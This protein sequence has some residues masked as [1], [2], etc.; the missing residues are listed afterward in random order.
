[1]TS[2][3][4]PDRARAIVDDLEARTVDLLAA[5]HATLRSDE[6]DRRTT[7]GPTEATLSLLEPP[8]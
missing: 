3:L 1:M 6:A 7:R 2:D 4:T 5:L 8:D